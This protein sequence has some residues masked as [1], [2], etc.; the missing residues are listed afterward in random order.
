M[1]GRV[2]GPLEHLAELV[3]SDAPP[4]DQEAGPDKVGIA[5]RLAGKEGPVGVLLEG[6]GDLPQQRL[7]LGPAGLAALGALQLVELHS[8]LG[9]AGAVPVGDAG[10]VE[11]PL[12]DG[13]HVV[14]AQGGHEVGQDG[15]ELGEVGRVEVEGRLRVVLVDGLGDDLGV[16]DEPVVG[17]PDG[18]AGVGVERG[19]EV[20]GQA[21]FEFRVLDELGLVVEALEVEHEAGLPRVEGPAPVAILAGEVE[22]R[23][24][25][26]LGCHFACVRPCVAGMRVQ[27]MESPADEQRA[28][29]TFG[30]LGLDNV[31]IKAVTLYLEAG[32]RVRA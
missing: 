9:L 23:D 20:R 25:V 21:W 16:H 11:Q 6:V 22:E 30:L 32:G 17:V 18:G 13:G 14:A 31:I 1:R 5:D 2:A 19:V 7:C 3:V 27:T 4:E 24:L 26:V 15:L 28:W 10:V 29:M 8:E 12:G